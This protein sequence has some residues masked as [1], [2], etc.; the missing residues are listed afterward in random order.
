MGQEIGGGGRLPDEYQEVAYAISD[1]GSYIDYVVPKEPFSMLEVSYDNLSPRSE[2]VFFGET[3]NPDYADMRISLELQSEE[4]NIFTS[5][6]TRWEIINVDI[7]PY[8]PNLLGK[9]LVK[10]DT[11]S[12]D[13]TTPSGKN[14]HK[15]LMVTAGWV[16]KGLFSLGYHGGGWTSLQGYIYCFKLSLGDALVLDLVPCYRKD[17]KQVG[18]YNLVDNTFR[19]SDGTPYS[20]GPIV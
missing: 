18:F 12:I 8:E 4:H 3:E 1:L 2:V 7:L 6:G 16:S 9:Y 13:I 14:I 19:P 5:R 20:A 17:T 15:N 10:Y 11:Q